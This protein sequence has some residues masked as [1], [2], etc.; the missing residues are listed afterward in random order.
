VLYNIDLP[1]GV[2][3]MNVFNIQSTCDFE[4]SISTEVSPIIQFN[5]SGVFPVTLIATDQDNNFSSITKEITVTDNEAPDGTLVFNEAY[6]IADEINFVF[7][8]E[9]AIADYLWDFGDESS[10]TDANP[11]YQFAT[12]G[13]YMITLSVSSPEGCSNQF[14]KTITIFE[15]ADPDFTTVKE[16]YCTFELITFENLTGGDY[17][18]NITY[19]WDFN[20]EGASDAAN[21]DFSFESTG[22]KTIRLTANVLDCETFI[23]KSIN[24]IEG[25]EVDFEIGAICVGESISLTNQST[26]DNIT[27]YIWEADEEEFSTE[28][29]TEITFELVGTYQI[30]LTVSNA[31]GCENHVEKEIRVFDQIIADIQ[32]SEATENLPFSTV[33]ELITDQ[34]YNITEYAWELNGET[35]SEA[36][37][38][39][40][41]EQGTYELGLSITT[42]AGCSFNFQKEI[43]VEASVFPTPDFSFEDN[44]CLNETIEIDNLSI[45]SESYQW[46]FCPPLFGEALLTSTIGSNSSL[47]FNYGLAVRKEGVS[48]KGISVRNNGVVYRLSFNDTFSSMESNAAISEISTANF[49]SPR[50]IKITNIDNRYHAFVTNSGTRVMTKLD[51]GNSLDNVPTVSD[52]ILDDPL[53][54]TH[55][56]EVV[57][58]GSEL[59]LFAGKQTN[60]R[61]Y[62]LVYDTLDL[63]TVKSADFFTIG[64]VS[65][66]TGV[67]ITKYG[68][69]HIGLAASVG[70]DKV[71]LLEF[72]NGLKANPLIT[73]LSV[74]EMDNPTRVL[75]DI[76][77]D[78][79]Y[80]FI[81]QHHF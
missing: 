33:A 73:P 39:W 4:P 21:P 16:E 13:E 24:I 49:S 36:I 72:T 48:I 79:L 40:N 8:T 23:E 55:G 12:A 9:D 28:E 46:Y 43:T 53:V 70:S 68:N 59:I 34:P 64:S 32:I 31:S 62:R 3:R 65:N 41:F 44:L 51:F 29:H 50:E 57:K 54:Q 52:I 18:D 58:E 1:V 35:S 11:Q 2:N 17:G 67:S 27:G 80:G 30:R 37:P 63:T 7:E 77:Q 74:S 66:I 78:R 76:E 5:S 10:S 69:K 71:Y 15:E 45:N 42:D 47:T 6:C 25:P 19:S 20:G 61:V 56:L 75:L 60:N 22:I 26:G 81:Q 14:S 38:T